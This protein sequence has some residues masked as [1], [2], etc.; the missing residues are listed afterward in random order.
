[1]ECISCKSKVRK[2]KT[3]REYAGI[4]IKNIDCM[5]CPKC[6]E[7]YFTGEQQRKLESIAKELGVFGAPRMKRRLGRS[8]SNIILRIP[9]DI[10]HELGL[11]AG[12]S[13]SLWKE[14]KRIV[15]SPL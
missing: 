12:D 5:R 10:A 15:I 3:V 4:E 14:G 9:K 2:S 13:V 8:G 7:E 11:D 1:M 6:G